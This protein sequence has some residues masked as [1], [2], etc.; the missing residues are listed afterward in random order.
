MFNF[1]N[2]IILNVPEQFMCLKEGIVKIKYE[3]I[4][5]SVGG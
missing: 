5:S 3:N 2:K 1:L 4:D